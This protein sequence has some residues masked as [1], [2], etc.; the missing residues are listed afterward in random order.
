MTLSSIPMSVEEFSDERRV[1]GRQQHSKRHE[2]HQEAFALYGSPTEQCVRTHLA[3]N[4]PC[5]PALTQNVMVYSASELILRPVRLIF[6]QRSVG[7]DR[8]GSLFHE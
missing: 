2:Q 5:F 1:S 8:S 7:D 4:H 3:Y 6:G